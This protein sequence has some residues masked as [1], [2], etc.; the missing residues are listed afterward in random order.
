MS[1]YSSEVASGAASR[2]PIVGDP[3]SAAE[4]IDRARAF[5]ALGDPIRLRLLSLIAAAAEGEVCVC[6]LNAPFDVAGPTISHHLK[7]LRQAGFIQGHRR[8]TWIYY[9]TI[10]AALDELATLLTSIGDHQPVP[11]LGTV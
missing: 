7:V 10:P 6:D 8:G 1:N 5:R 4:A 9:Q 2:S 11:A 3:L